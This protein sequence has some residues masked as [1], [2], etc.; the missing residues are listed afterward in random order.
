MNTTY[1]TKSLTDFFKILF[2]FS[3]LGL[4]F[5]I[6]ATNLKTQKRTDFSTGYSIPVKIKLIV[7]D[8]IIQY[9]EDGIQKNTYLK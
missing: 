9:H 8:S 2:W 3:V 1:L 4:V 6:G 7:H 5:K